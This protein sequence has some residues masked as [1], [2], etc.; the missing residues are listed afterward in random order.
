MTV[1]E[2]NKL[3]SKKDSLEQE[4]YRRYRENVPDGDAEAERMYI[5]IMDK[6]RPDLGVPLL[7]YNPWDK[8]DIDDIAV[9]GYEEF[10]RKAIEDK[11]LLTL[12]AEKEGV[13]KWLNVQR[14][15]RFNSNYDHTHSFIE[16]NYMYSGS[17]TNMVDGK[18]IRMEAGDFIIMKPGSSHRIVWAGE[19][20]L[21][22]NIILLPHAADVIL[23]KVLVGTSE[24]SAFLVEALYSQE[25]RSNYLFL[26]TRGVERIRNAMANLMCEYYGEAKPTTEVLV[27][28]YLQEVFALLWKE[29]IECPENVL[30]ANRPSPL[31]SDII[32]YIQD[33]CVSCTRETLAKHFGYSGSRVSN[34]LTE[35][36]GRSLVELR[37]EFRM[38]I[39]DK[40]LSASDMTVRKVAE[41]CGYT[42]IT[43]F[44]KVYKERFGKL[45]RTY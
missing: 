35:H 4:C 11:R 8:D 44:Y 2:L 24:L 12:R 37:N 15:G 27:A 7:Y 5:E 34:L 14:H 28:C 17:C 9:G 41:E 19:N 6:N 40:L 45:P 21:L 25:S 43:Q 36:I 22:M 13:R 10:K 29:S 42:N 32:S 3:L 18:E 26:R 39:A 23:D 33:N 31:V 1:V 20:D 16:I 38:E 30:Y